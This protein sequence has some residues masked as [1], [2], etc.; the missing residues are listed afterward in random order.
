MIAFFDRLNFST[1]SNMVFWVLLIWAAFS[2]VSFSTYLILAF[3]SI[4]YP[5]IVAALHIN[6]TFF[7]FIFQDSF[8]TQKKYPI[9]ENLTFWAIGVIIFLSIVGIEWVSFRKH[10]FLL[11]WRWRYPRIGILNDMGWNSKNTEIS[12][13]TDIPPKDWAKLIKSCGFNVKFIKINDNFDQY[14]AIL[15]PYG[16][17]YPEVD[18]RTLSSQKKILGFVNEGGIFVNVSDIPTYYAYNIKLKRR[19]DTTKPV[20][21]VNKDNQLIPIRL[22]QLTPLMKELGL[23]VLNIPPQPQ[24]FK[25]FSELETDIVTERVAIVES[26]I[27]PFLPTTSIG[28]IN[29]TAFFA[30]PYGEGDFIFS[31]LFLSHPL[32]NQKAKDIIKEAI[33]AVM[34]EKIKK[35][36]SK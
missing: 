36:K 8:I 33:V 31:L 21:T 6:L 7:I 26:N 34:A 16:S 20:F 2:F 35:K 27:E 5:S 10:R 30:V 19:V 9:S 32:H 11:T 13:W 18:L 22:F 23:S 14:V 1:D 4:W 15:N 25:R 29:T 24:N 12:G 28:K 3:K 17:V